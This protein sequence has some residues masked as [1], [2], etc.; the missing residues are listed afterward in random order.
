MG[1]FCKSP[2]PRPALHHRVPGPWAPPETE[3]PA[4][5]PISTLLFGRPGQT[6]I[7]ITGMSA[8]SNGFEI[9]VHA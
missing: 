8:Y 9:F 3:F 7:A 5:V 4:I 2:P 6:A 1:L